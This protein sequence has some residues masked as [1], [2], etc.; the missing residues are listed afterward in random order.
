MKLE[1]DKERGDLL[2]AALENFRLNNVDEKNI[3]A[4]TKLLALKRAIATEIVEGLKG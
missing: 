2:L 3:E 1:L 4:V